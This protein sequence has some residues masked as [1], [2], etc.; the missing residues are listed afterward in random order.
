MFQRRACLGGLL[1]SLTLT[2]YASPV[3]IPNASFE[4]PLAP[5]LSPYAFPDVVEWQKT[6]Q[7]F[8]YNPNDFQGSPWEYLL[9]TFYNAH[10]SDPD[11]FIDNADGQQGAF[12]F[13]VPGVGLFQDYNSLS[14][15]NS[16]PSH[17]FNATFEVGSAYDLT[18]GVI[19]G[20]GG[21]KP[22]VT[23][24][25]GLYYRDAASNLMTVATTTV[26][27]SS[28]TFPTNTHFV[29]FQVH[30]PTVQAGDPWAGQ[31]IGIQILS[32]VSFD[33]IGGY[34]DVDNVRLDKTPAPTLLNS[35][36]T[37][38]GFTFTVN[39]KPGQAVEMFTTTNLLTV[40]S[41][42]I[43]L[44]TFTNVTGSTNFSHASTNWNQRFYRAQ[45]R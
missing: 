30:V 6:P 1:A 35:A 5:R 3:G 31:N 28:A 45:A 8:W 43:S 36:F 10:V 41:N 15:T 38:N 22:G 20:G 18:V 24:L 9:G 11:T 12:L 26:I 32:A 13:A 44:G 29:D 37:T 34:W 16:I 19:G 40:A 14:G 7:P 4:A 39:S 23:L 21:M 25:L 42:W 17:A 2:I 27:H 33:L